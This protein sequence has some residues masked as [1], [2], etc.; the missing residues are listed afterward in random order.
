MAEKSNIIDIVNGIS[1]AAA[2]AYDG[3][4]DENVT[5]SKHDA[6]SQ[7]AAP[8]TADQKVNMYDFIATFESKKKKRKVAKKAK[9]TLEYFMTA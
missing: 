4:L 2:N 9:S 8:M 7:G 5:L 3:A 1:Q 6:E